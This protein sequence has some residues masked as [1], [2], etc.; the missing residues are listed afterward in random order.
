MTF[1]GTIPCADCPGIELTVTLLPDGTFRLRQRYLERDP[2]STWLDLGRWT[3]E[4]GGRLV[5]R[6]AGERPTW[7]A[8]FAW[9]SLRLLDGEG[10]EIASGLPY[11]LGRVAEVDPVPDVQRLEGMVT[12]SAGAMVFAECRTGVAFPVSP[13]GAHA[14]LERAHRDASG[15]SA[16][17]LLVRVR[18]S[19]VPIR[20]P[21]DPGAASL[22]LEAVEGSVPGAG[23]GEAAADL[24]LEGTEWLLLELGGSPLPPTL[25]ATLLL[26]GA[27]GRASGR[28]GCNTFVVPYRLAGASLTFGDLAVTGVVCNAAVMDVEGAYLRTLARVG[29]YR[30]TGDRL[31]LL[32]EEGVAA[33]FRS[34]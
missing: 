1:R 10:R 34:R 23:C 16:E 6:G 31:Q 32:A 5:L 19:L 13:E 28:G 26:N 15:G 29:G 2:L 20:S 25:E 4:D 22:V 14:E 3:E 12:W 11:G 33:R 18:G 8:R 27:D 7:F 17:P 21:G 30:L 24:P 9:D